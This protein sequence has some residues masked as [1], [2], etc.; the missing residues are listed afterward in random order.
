MNVYILYALLASATVHAVPAIPNEKRE[1]MRKHPHGEKGVEHG[2]GPVTAS[3][4]SSAIVSPTLAAGVAL[5]GSAAEDGNEEG[6]DSGGEQWRSSQTS[7]TVN[8]TGTLPAP[9]TD[10]A[11]V[12][13]GAS[14]PD[15][16]DMTPPPDMTPVEGALSQTSSTQHAPSPSTSANPSPVPITGSEIVARSNGAGLAINDQSIKSFSGFTKGSLGWYTG[17]AATPL[18]G[19]NGLEWV[20]QVWGLPQVANIKDQAK[21]WPTSVKYVLSFNE[22]ESARFLLSTVSWQLGETRRLTSS[23]H[24]RQRGRI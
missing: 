14:P 11:I 16:P 8:Q 12:D 4:A 3:Q 15:G 10:P 17:W 20:P 19:T 18:S 6:T 2:S 24:G 22:R 9:S 21:N 5:E 13:K 1:C 23:G 7:Q